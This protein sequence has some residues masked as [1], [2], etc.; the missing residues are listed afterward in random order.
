MDD[1]PKTPLEALQKAVRLAGGQAKLAKAVGKAGQSYISMLLHRLKN[2]PDNT[3][4][5][6]DIC[7]DIETATSGQ[8]T[9]Q[10]LRPDFAWVVQA[11]GA[12]QQDAAA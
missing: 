3:K 8:V 11:D 4:I 1:T 6:A 12:A 7:P 10:Q 2:D 5:D 9:R